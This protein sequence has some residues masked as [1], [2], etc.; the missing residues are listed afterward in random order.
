MKRLP[1]VPLALVT[2]LLLTLSFAVS[3]PTLRT[4]L[5]ALTGEDRLLSQLRGLA[6]I[7]IDQTRPPLALAPAQVRHVHTLPPHGVNTFLQGE[8][9]IAKRERSLRMIK[10]AGFSWIRQQFPWSDIEIHAKG[11]FEDRRNPPARSAWDKYDNIVALSAAHG[12]EIIARL[13]APPKWAHAGYADLGD[14]GPPARFED[15]ADYVAGVVARYKGRIRYYQ[16]WNEPNIYPEWGDQAVNPEDYVRMLCLAAQRARSIDPNVVIIAAALAP[17]VDQSGLPPGGLNDLIFLQR[18]YAAGAG[19]CFD[20]LSAQGYGLWSGPQD[21]RRDPQNTNVARHVLMRDVMVRNGDAH[22]PIW[23]AEVNW[24]PVPA[25]Q[26]DGKPIADRERFGVVTPAEQA[27]Y[28]PALLARA[29]T[30]WPWVGVTSVWFFK[31]PS[32][33]E[34]GQS[35]YY[36]R[37]VEPDFTPTVLYDAVKQALR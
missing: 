20:V 11:D 15:Y 33:D 4:Q 19:A 29:R 14:F 32:D 37:M 7:M 16:L 34:R 2:L 24:N 27:R 1:I 26:P 6:A 9:E 22:K 10:D 12:L 5:E 31:R 18:M 36:F 25:A 28:V 8:V 13:D 3:Q 21:T 23:L 35:W 30:D 17:T